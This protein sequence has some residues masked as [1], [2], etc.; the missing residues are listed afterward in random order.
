MKLGIVVAGLT[1]LTMGFLS[2]TGANSTDTS[3]EK[4]LE[5][6]RSSSWRHEIVQ[7]LVELGEGATP[8]ICSA[9]AYFGTGRPSDTAERGQ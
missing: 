3:E 8:A 9:Y 1:A 2:G 6:A 7:K 4:V 5:I